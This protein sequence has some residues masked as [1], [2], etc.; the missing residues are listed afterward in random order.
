ML[1]VFDVLL[2]NDRVLTNQALRDRK[3]VI[4]DVFNPVAGRLIVSEISTGK[5][6]Y[7]I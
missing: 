4:A 6:K 5:T 2:L 1:C 7:V 3:R